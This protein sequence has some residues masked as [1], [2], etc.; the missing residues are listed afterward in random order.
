MRVTE[1]SE[2]P[3]ENLYIPPNPHCMELAIQG[4]EQVQTVEM[5]IKSTLPSLLKQR[6][7]MDVG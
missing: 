6:E 2:T 7:E 4:K 1:R 5:Q 3:E